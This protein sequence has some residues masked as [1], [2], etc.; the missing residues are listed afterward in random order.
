MVGHLGA[1]SMRRSICC[2]GLL[3][4][5]PLLSGCFMAN[6][7]RLTAPTAGRELMD[8]KTARDNGALTDEE[9]QSKRQEI[10]SGGRR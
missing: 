3:L 8:L 6:W 5:T 10:L 9:Y 1:Y 2:L 4:L 7:Q